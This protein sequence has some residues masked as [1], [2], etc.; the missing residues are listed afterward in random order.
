MLQLYAW[1]CGPCLATGSADSVHLLPKLIESLE[2]DF[3]EDVVMG[4]NHCLSLTRRK[5]L[6]GQI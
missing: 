4:D 6:I 1:G 3:I 2:D 5:F